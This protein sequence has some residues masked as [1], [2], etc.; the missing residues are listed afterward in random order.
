MTYDLAIIGGGPAGAAAAVYAARKHLRSVFITKDWLGQS[1][2]SEKVENWIGTTAI[3][4]L[5]LSMNLEKHAKAY[6]EGVIDFKEGELAT[7]ITKTGDNFTITTSKENYEA[8]TVLI[9]SGSSRR[10]LTVP[11]AETYEHKGLTYCASCDGPMYSG[12]DVAVVGGGNAGFESAAQ[13]LAYCKSV[14]LLSRSEFKA[15]PG[16]VEKVL[17][18][19][20]MKAFEFTVPKEVKGGQ[21]VTSLIYTDTK[22]GKDTEISV[23]GIFAEIGSMPNT[24]F[25]KDIV[26][27]DKFNHIIVDARNQR[28]SDGIWA[29][30][31]CTDG[32]YHQN[33]IAAGD[34][35]KAVE[36]IYL[37]INAK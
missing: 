6:A 7:N 11:G 5:E 17:S 15:D 2:V 20:K 8:K 13:L 12:Q 19:P 9:V 4:G 25:A 33:N 35:V 28:A 34:A 16:T 27:L 36:D 14:T 23:T 29:A 31:D 26:R 32:L 22:S 24:D 21:F 37:Y 1:N 18:N 10:K 30:G 3:S